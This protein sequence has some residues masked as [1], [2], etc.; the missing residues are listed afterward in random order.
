MR[1]TPIVVLVTDKTKAALDDY[2]VVAESFTVQDAPDVVAA[3]ERVKAANG[4]TPEML[5][6]G[7]LLAEAL[8]TWAQFE[9]DRGDA[10]MSRL[11]APG[12]TIT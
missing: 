2:V 4:W 11:D 6:G 9:S 8:G 5:I 12:G 3:L 7:S 10:Y 1:L